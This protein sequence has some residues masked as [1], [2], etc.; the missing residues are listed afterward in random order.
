ADV[1]KLRAQLVETLPALE[2]KLAV[3]LSPQLFHGAPVTGS[4]E[5]PGLGKRPADLLASESGAVVE[6][7]FVVEQIRQTAHHD[8]RSTP[9]LDDAQRAAIVELVEPWKSRP[10]NFY[11]L[12]A[13]LGQLGLWDSVVHTPGASGKT[14]EA[15]KLY[16]ADQIAQTGAL[17]DVG[18]LDDATL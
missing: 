3:E 17:A 4:L 2:A 15:T 11:F 12:A 5:T 7:L 13:V 18:E 8:G 6:L 16:V 10:V 14:L 9:I 1:E